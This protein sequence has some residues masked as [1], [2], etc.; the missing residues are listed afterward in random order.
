MTY[1]K[2]KSYV[3]Q[4]ELA[5]LLNFSQQSISRK[6]KELE[7]DKLIVRII[8][9][10][11]EIIRLTEEGEKFLNTCLTSLKDA[12]LSLHSIEIRGNIVSGLG[13]GK[14]FL[15]MEYYKTQINKIMGF[16]PYPG[17]LNIVIY[18]KQSLENR[19]LLD[20]SPSLLIPEYKQKDRVLGAVKLYPA[21][22]NSIKP[23]AVV[24]PLRTTHPK[25]VIEIISPFY[26]RE[27]LNLKDGDEVTIEVYV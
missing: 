11:G 22:I 12:I 20:S 9:K 1:S 7:E 27:K 2:G 21:S 19:L 23:A 24:M 4:T 8:S 6:L 18:D 13:E 25:S 5:R 14:I 26:L 15:S 3:T 10:E 17:T 16:D